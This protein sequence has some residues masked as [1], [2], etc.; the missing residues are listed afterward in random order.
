MQRGSLD[1][2]C[3]ANSQCNKASDVSCKRQ[4]NA[5]HRQIPLRMLMDH[6]LDASITQPWLGVIQVLWASHLTDLFIVI[7]LGRQF[8]QLCPMLQISPPNCSHAA[9]Q[10]STSILSA[11]AQTAATYS[12]AQV[13]VRIITVI[14]LVLRLCQTCMATCACAGL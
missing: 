8:K 13:Q 5:K 4:H 14:R 2:Q 11:A 6:D 9:K 12:D 10:D 1:L 7:V 3:L